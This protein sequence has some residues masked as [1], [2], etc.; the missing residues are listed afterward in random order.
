M[1]FNSEIQFKVADLLY[2]RVELLVSNVDKL[3]E[4]WAQSL[5][6]FNAYAPFDSHSE[7]HWIIDLSVLGDVP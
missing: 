4:L 1:P 7:M 3:L 5:A 2:R 6:D